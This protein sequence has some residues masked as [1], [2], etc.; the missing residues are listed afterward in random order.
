MHKNIYGLIFVYKYDTNILVPL[1]KTNT[2][3]NI[4]GLTKKGK[5]KYKLIWDENK[6]PFQI[7]I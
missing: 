3:T 7:Q 4:I 2:N 5:Y 6:G 1:Y